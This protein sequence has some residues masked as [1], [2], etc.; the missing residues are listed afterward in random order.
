M[1]KVDAVTADATAADVASAELKSPK[2][3]RSATR[4]G[5]EVGGRACA[6]GVLTALILLRVAAPPSPP[7]G[8]FLAARSSTRFLAASDGALL[9]AKRCCTPLTTSF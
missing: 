3:S 7:V 4:A 5:A 1:P 9:F 8:W 6:E 2:S